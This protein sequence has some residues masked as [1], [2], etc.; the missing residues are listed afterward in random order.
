MAVGEN[1]LFRSLSLKFNF[2]QTPSSMVMAFSMLD[3]HDEKALNDHL[4][5]LPD[6]FPTPITLHHK[7]IITCAYCSKDKMSIATFAKHL[8]SFCVPF[9]VFEENY[10]HAEALN[11][12]QATESNRK[13]RFVWR[14]YFIFTALLTNLHF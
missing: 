8:T 12:V 10:S 3:V 7:H 4:D 1:H 14:F 11:K 5:A 13:V 6:L 2:L 9:L